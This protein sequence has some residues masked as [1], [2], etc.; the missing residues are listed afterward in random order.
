MLFPMP[1]QKVRQECW[2]R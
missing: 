1:S 2:T